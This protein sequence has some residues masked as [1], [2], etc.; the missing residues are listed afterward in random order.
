M[1]NVD[2]KKI[3]QRLVSVINRV[4]DLSVMKKIELIT[5]L[6]RVL[7]VHLIEEGYSP[8]V[9]PEPSRPPRVAKP[10]YV[11]APDEDAEAERRKNYVEGT[12][13]AVVSAQ[14]IKASVR[15]C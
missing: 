2:D 15:C 4:D 3:I 8:S 9:L 13:Y 7:R 10:S 11:E 5:S 12:L 6:F 1:A 14:K